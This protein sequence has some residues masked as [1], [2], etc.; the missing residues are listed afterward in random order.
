MDSF[1]IVFWKHEISLS[2]IH[3]KVVCEILRNTIGESPLDKLYNHIQFF[4][5]VA[6]LFVW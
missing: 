4:F 6:N 1:F 5:S 3:W 2:A